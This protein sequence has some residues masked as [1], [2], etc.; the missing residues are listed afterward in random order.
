MHDLQEVKWSVH[1]KDCNGECRTSKIISSLELDRVNAGDSHIN[2]N[3]D[4][5]LV[6]DD[7]EDDI[8][9]PLLEREISGDQSFIDDWLLQLGHDDKDD[10]A[11]DDTENSH[12]EV[13]PVQFAHVKNDDDAAHRLQHP[14][15]E[16]NDKD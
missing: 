5:V 3:E 13:L 6:S 10:A 9:L 12:V 1:E 16:E 4:E 2:S 11:E 7:D 8:N 14:F 15:P